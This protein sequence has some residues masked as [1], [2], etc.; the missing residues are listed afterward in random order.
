MPADACVCSYVCLLHQAMRNSCMCLYMCL[1]VSIH[2]SFSVCTC[3]FQC[4]YMCLSVSVHVS[5]S[6][7]QNANVSVHTLYVD[8]CSARVSVDVSVIVWESVQWVSGSQSYHSW[9]IL[10]ATTSSSPPRPSV[11]RCQKCEW[12]VRIKRTSVCVFA[13]VRVQYL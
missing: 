12:R 4:L 5:I 11:R 9:A 1:S 7:I 10:G 6:C 8:T 13:C 3:V 2:V